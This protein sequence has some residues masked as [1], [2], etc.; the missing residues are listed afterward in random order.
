MNTM[1]ILS[2]RAR[3]RLIASRLEA[4]IRFGKLEEGFLAAED[5]SYITGVVLAVG[6]ARTQL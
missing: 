1:A 5:G 2:I 4:H 6:G 3:S